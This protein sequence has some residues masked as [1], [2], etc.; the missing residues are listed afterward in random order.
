LERF[1]DSMKRVSSQMI[2]SLLG[3]LASSALIRS[4][5]G[6]ALPPDRFPPNPLLEGQFTPSASPAAKLTQE[7][8]NLN[9]QAIAKLEAGNADAAFDLWNQ[10][11]RL[12]RNLGPAGEVKALAQVG[13]VAWT[14][15]NTRQVRY[16]RQRLQQIQAQPQPPLA[17]LAVAYEVIRAPELA[18]TVYQQ[19]LVTQAN[20]PQA[21][22][23][24]RN[25]T[26]Q[27]Q[28][29]WFNYRQAATVYQD[30]LTQAQAENNPTNQLAY[31][32]QL[33]YVQE[34]ARNPQG[35]IAAL[36]IL[37]DRY[38]MTRDPRLLANFQTRLADQYRRNQQPDAAERTYQAAY[39]TAE[40][41]QQM[42]FAG[43][44]LRQLAAF[45]REQQRFDAAIQV[46]D[47][48]TS[49]EQELGRNPFN[50]M[51]A[52]D[53][54]GQIYLAQGNRSQAIAAF[55]QGLRL[56]QQ[57]NHRVAYFQ[58][59]LNPAPPQPGRRS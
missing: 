53:R 50:T 37:I 15:N 2:V 34:Q 52:Y 36:E 45:Y 4:P 10:Q 13:E 48:L 44:A 55:S 8:A 32:Y 24:W 43:D 56:A 27:T 26:A 19:G 40:A 51:D 1:V 31:A 29:D 59:Q 30:L 12:S 33:A 25:R 54:L 3:G 9:Q 22:F 20:D 38:R 39:R 14:R 16:I 28:L 49:F 23:Q 42:G 41:Q 57:L 18:L 46:Y 21:L 5:I 58:A 11:L 7:L 47:F 6:V 35:A 17:E